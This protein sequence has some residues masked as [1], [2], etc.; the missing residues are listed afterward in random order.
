MPVYEY[1]CK[2]CEHQFDVFVK[3]FNHQ[4]SDTKCEAC[5]KGPCIRQ[6]TAPM[7]SIS[8]DGP[9]RYERKE[10]EQ[11]KK[12]KDPERAR[13]MR[14]DKFGT[15]GISITKSPHYHKQKQVK[16]QGKSDVDKKEFIKHAA[17]NPKAVA[18]AAS[19]LKLS[20]G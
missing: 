1:I 15:E 6:L 9:D 8:P 10:V 2:Q 19:A 7:I 20:K 3:G 12:V 4:D 16:A 18:A 5:G 11:S 13:K 17:R 14:K